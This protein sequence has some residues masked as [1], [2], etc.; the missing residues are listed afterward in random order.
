L[1]IEGPIVFSL[2]IITIIF[3]AFLFIFLLNIFQVS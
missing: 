2:F 1:V 3:L